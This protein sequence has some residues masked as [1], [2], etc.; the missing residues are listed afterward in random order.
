MCSTAVSKQSNRGIESLAN[1]KWADFEALQIGGTAISPS[2]DRDLPSQRQPC[3]VWH[4]VYVA[5]DPRHLFERARLRSH[6]RKERTLA[7]ARPTMLAFPSFNNDCIFV[8]IASHLIPLKFSRFVNPHKFGLEVC[9]SHKT[10]PY[11]SHQ[12]FSHRESKTVQNIILS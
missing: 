9:K 2:L 3:F 12:Y 1:S 10:S 6:P 8:L 4:V 11:K 7:K 5:R